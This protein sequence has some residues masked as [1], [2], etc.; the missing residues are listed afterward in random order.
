MPYTIQP[1]ENGIAHFMCLND[2]H[3]VIR[4]EKPEHPEHLWIDAGP[5][6]CGVGN[7]SFDTINGIGESV[8]VNGIAYVK[9]TDKTHNN[10]YTI[11]H[12]K[13]FLTT[14]VFMLG[15]GSNPHY[16]IMGNTSPT[17]ALTDLYQQ[18]YN[19]TQQPFLITGKI[20]CETLNATA[21]AKAPIDGED[22]FKHENIYYPQKTEL[23]NVHGIV[24]GVVA[25]MSKLTGELA[26]K[27]NKV[28]YFNPLEGK[29]GVL[30]THEHALILN[31]N[32][33]VDVLHVFPQMVL[34]DFDLDVYLIS[35]IEM[36]TRK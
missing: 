3:D 23:N 4:G 8:I 24:V 7:G 11:L 12:G 35:D 32:S 16:R 9:T 25:D 5:Y 36:L 1:L 33:K 31:D 10:Y 19:E 17:L 14:W 18:I 29:P 30:T 2:I 21:I 20:H 34:L 26:E 28:V 15:K 13:T 27:M 22:I 6:I